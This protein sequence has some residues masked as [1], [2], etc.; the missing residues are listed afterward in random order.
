MAVLP[1]TP[2]QIKARKVVLM[3]SLV[4][5]VFKQLMRSGS[6]P[7]RVADALGP[8]SEITQGLKNPGETVEQTRERVIAEF[9]AKYP[10]LAKSAALD[11]SA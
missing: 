11:L 8:R 6:A 10:L 4:D 5:R 3:T 7:V 9:A 1:A 2:Q